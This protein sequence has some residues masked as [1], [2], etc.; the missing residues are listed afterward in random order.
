MHLTSSFVKAFVILLL[1]AFV[2][3]CT[4]LFLSILINSN[5]ENV[6]LLGYVAIVCTVVMAVGYVTF[7]VVMLQDIAACEY[8]DQCKRIARQRRQKRAK[9]YPAMKDSDWNFKEE[10]CCI[11]FDSKGKVRWE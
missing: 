4:R 8:N 11:I 6:E 3:V 7:V 5:K 2:A 9:V 10:S 1:G